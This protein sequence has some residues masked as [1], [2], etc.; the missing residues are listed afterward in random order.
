MD[1]W[2]RV[3]RCD[4]EYLAMGAPFSV[5][6]VISALAEKQQHIP[7]RNSK[8]TYLLQTSLGGA[9]KTLMVT[10]VAGNHES[11]QEALCSLRFAQKVN[12]CA[13]GKKAA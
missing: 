3:A 1:K 9:A 5:G 10:N 2:P 8:L 12:S 6:D 7:Y 11:S 13:V 4:V